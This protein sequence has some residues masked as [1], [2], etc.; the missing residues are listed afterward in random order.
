MDINFLIGKKIKARRKELSITQAELAGDKISRNMLSL[1]ENGSAMPSVDTAEYIA[2]RLNLPLSYLFSDSEDLFPFEKL[3]KIDYI[4]EMF[5]KG[6]YSRCINLIDSLSG[7]DDELNYISATAAFRLGI[8]L[9]M[10]GSF[11]SAD[12]YFG[13]AI[14]RSKATAYDTK[15]IRTVTPMYQAVLGNVQSPLLEFDFEAFKNGYEAAYNY[16]FF[17]YITL[18]FDF[19]FSNKLFARHF[20]AKSLIK[21]YNYQEAIKV[22]LSMEEYKNSK[23][24][25]ACVMFGVYTD[26]EY[27]YK[28]LG[29]FE[30][31]YR[32]S[33][34]RLSL[35][36]AFQT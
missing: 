36:N 22:L 29:D 16:E 20:E 2:K 23:D 6:N 34:K 21:K 35:L 4:K 26:L 9:T 33:N 32:Y 31:A 27:S 15:E 13:I 14:E 30:N 5:K 19:D 12:K 10:Q 28:Q 17:K 25:N 11:L 1:I 7:T 8:S 24:Y 3:E 18:D